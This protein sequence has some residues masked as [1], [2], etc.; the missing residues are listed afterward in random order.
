MSNVYAQQ[1]T[2]LNQQEQQQLQQQIHSQIESQQQQ[3]QQQIHS[4]NETQQ[5]QQQQPIAIITHSADL[6][7]DNSGRTNTIQIH[8]ITTVPEHSVVY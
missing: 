3:L 6:N 8:H 7:D 2:Q 1:P 5:Q 4:Q